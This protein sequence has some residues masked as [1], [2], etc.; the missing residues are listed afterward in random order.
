M[1]LPP[2]HPFRSAAARAR[3]LERYDQ[4]AVTW[5]IPS[6]EERVETSLGQTF[7]RVSGPDDAPPLL[8][9][10][11]IG[12]ASL[13]WLPVVGGLSERSRLY[14]IDNVYDVG[15]SVW[16]SAPT[17]GDDFTAWLLELID[18]LS[19][20]S[21]GLL[22][23]SYGAWIAASFALAH[24]ERIEALALFAPAATVAPLSTQFLVR[25]ASCALPLRAFSRRFMRWL[26]ADTLSRGPAGQA[27]VDEVEED[28]AVA[29]ACFSRR[30]LVPPTLLTD[31]ALASLPGHT[32]FL[33]GS[34]DPVFDVGAAE[35][36]LATVAPRVQVVIVPGAGH[37]LPLAR[38]GVFSEHVN[39][40]LGR[41]RG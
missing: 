37:D 32:L 18:G 41:Q 5:P 12:S 27:L 30:R 14:A 34:H 9:L 1:S 20:S 7:V 15:R 2:H 36:R 22:G 17:S 16:T 19:L 25:A 33:A 39:A 35:R 6:H 23:A 38:P 21:V 4:R 26:A 28:A 8:L 10:P 13:M 3:Y 24:P 11:G 40:S 31:G 29:M